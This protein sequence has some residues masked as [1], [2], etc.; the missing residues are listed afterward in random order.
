MGGLHVG[1]SATAATDTTGPIALA[2]V[3]M[4]LIVI[5]L[6][7]DIRYLRASRRIA[8]DLDLPKGQWLRLVRSLPIDPLM[9][10]VIVGVVL[11]EDLVQSWEHVVVGLVGAAL[12]IAGGHF[13]YRIQ[14]VRAVPE[15][16]AIIFV[17]SRTEYVALAILVVVRLAAEQHQIPVVGPLTL[18][19]TG[20][21]AVVVFESVGRSWF[22]YRRFRSEAGATAAVDIRP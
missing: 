8:K 7:V 13:R 9:E 19:V 16:H 17:R 2:L 1:M 5:L 11:A 10:L 6:V 21:L 15:R 20:L 22:S 18:L 12:G 3:S 4:G 14:Y